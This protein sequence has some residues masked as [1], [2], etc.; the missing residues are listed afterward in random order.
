MNTPL[1]SHAQP[2]VDDRED[3]KSRL[4]DLAM[5]L[6]DYRERL[7]ASPDRLQ[8]VED[9]LAALD[10]LKRRYGPSLDDVVLRQAGLRTE[11]TDLG[12][13]EER[14]AALERAERDTRD[15]FQSAAGSLSTARK[16]AG[17]ALG[18][19]LVT[20][21][22]ELAMASCRV[23]VRQQP[24]ELP[25]R[26]S[27]RGTDEVEFF[28]SPNPGEDLRPLARIASGGE[29]S[30]FM[31]ALRL[32]TMREDGSQALIFDEVDAGIG[33]AAADAVGTRLQ[34]LGRRHQV[35]CVTHLA[36]IAARADA[37][38]EITKHVKTGRT[39]TTVLRLEGAEREREVGRMI[40]GAA[41][42]NT[43]LES[44]R[45]LLAS[46]QRSEEKPKAKAKPTRGESLNARG[47]R[48]A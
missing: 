46:G 21:L 42:S 44:A 33:G 39:H 43:V 40:A 20:D 14:A 12:A 17:A 30:R 13:G 29:M 47:R 1:D 48:G 31:L 8:A 23:E 5:F 7:D 6:R 26:W 41:V 37:H 19:A 15:A 32:Q 3:L 10:R 25:D 22:A 2:Y 45:E 24:I 28:F 38:F 35:L 36:Q 9:R 11:L 34:A 16:K 4:E 27:R 18:R